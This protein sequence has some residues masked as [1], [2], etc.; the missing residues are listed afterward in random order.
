MT[1]SRSKSD[2]KSILQS[3][4]NRRILVSTV[5]FDHFVWRTRKSYLSG[6]NSPYGLFRVLV[7][8]NVFHSEVKGYDWVL[9][10][11]KQSDCSALLLFC[12][13]GRQ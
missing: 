5:F 9:A 10:L 12:F 13:Y 3:S 8:F 4:F 1:D 7:A 11:M 6:M 2:A